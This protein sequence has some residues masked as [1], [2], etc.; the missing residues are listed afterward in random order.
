[1][2]VSCCGIAGEL[3]ADE[4][5]AMGMSETDMSESPV[6][7]RGRPEGVGYLPSPPRNAT[8]ENGS[9]AGDC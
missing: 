3:E 8:T 1:M 7:L 4:A 9:T 5:V 6:P 2:R